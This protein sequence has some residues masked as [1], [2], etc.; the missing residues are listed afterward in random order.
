LP[1]HWI[2][3]LIQSKGLCA[4]QFFLQTISLIGFVAFCSCGKYE[5]IW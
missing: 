1:V 3:S 4:A 2:L 5:V